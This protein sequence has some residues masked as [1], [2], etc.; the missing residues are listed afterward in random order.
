MSTQR[1][2][3]TFK[4]N[5]EKRIRAQAHQVVENKFFIE[6]SQQPQKELVWNCWNHAPW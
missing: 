6:S 1:Y 3:N 2:L 4:N 5:P